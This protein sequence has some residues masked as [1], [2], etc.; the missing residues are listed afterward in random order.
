MSP[1]KAAGVRPFYEF[2]SALGAPRAS[3]ETEVDVDV[4]MSDFITAEDE[5]LI[6]ALSDQRVRPKRQKLHHADSTN[7][8]TRFER[9]KHGTQRQS[10]K[11]GAA[12]LPPV[13]ESHVQ[14]I[15]ETEIVHSQPQPLQDS[16]NKANQLPVSTSSNEGEPESTPHSVKEREMAGAKAVSQLVSTRSR[17]S[18]EIAAVPAKDK[19]LKSK[20]RKQPTVK[21]R[22]EKPATKSCTKPKPN[23]SQPVSTPAEAAEDEAVNADTD[24][25]RHADPSVVQRP[26][27]GVVESIAPNRVFAY[28]K[29][30]YCKYYPAT[31]LGSSSLGDTWRV[32]FDDGTITSIGSHLVSRLAFRLDDQVKVDRKGMRDKTWTIKGFGRVAKDDQEH[33]AG[34]D[35]HG[36]ISVKVEARSNRTSEVAQVDG[37]LVEVDIRD[38]YLTPTMWPQFEVRRF[39]PLTNTKAI[40]SRAA[41]PSSGLPTPNAEAPGSRSRRGE[42]TSLLRDTSLVSERAADDRALFSGMAFGISYGSNEREKAEVTQLIQRNGGIIL[43][44]GFEQLFRL[45]SLDEPALESTKKPTRPDNSDPEDAGLQLKPEHAGLGFVALIADKHSRRAKYVQALALGLPT[46][47]GRWIVDSVHASQKGGNRTPSWSKYLLPA[48]ESVF[49]NGAVRSRTMPT[50]NAETTKL[51]DTIANRDMLLS[52]DG[53]LI[54]ASKKG[55]GTWERRKAYAF[56]TLALGAGDVKRVSDLEEVKSFIADEPEKWKWVYVEGSVND[57][58]KAICGKGAGAKKRKREEDTAAVDGKAMFATAGSVK[59]VNDE[60]VVQSLI[61]GALVD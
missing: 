2:D 4:V 45:P 23:L 47:S 5:E 40:A 7:S 41:T 49:L 35:M 42:R 29:D 8:A 44:S 52:G 48:G 60:F 37:A 30:P 57:A 28:C 58:S 6:S 18:V 39:N 43:E 34:T 56:L 10:K 32:R 38:V 31:W 13:D 59:I 9:V 14:I 51:A 11:G 3:G 54:I 22:R 24:E 55:K 33:H 16:P 19:T 17:K 25:Q 1:R 61:L 27:Y 20:A 46:L 53:V 21:Q 36:R 26:D 50:Y 12:E 15:D